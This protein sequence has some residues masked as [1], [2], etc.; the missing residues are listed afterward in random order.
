M[1]DSSQEFIVVL[2]TVP[3]SETGARLGRGL[4]EQHLAAC[5]NIIP[6]VRSLY[7]WEGEVKDDAEAQLLIKTRR[8]RYDELAEHIRTHHP[9]S[10]PEI[11]ALPIANG[12]ASYLAWI[13]AQT[14]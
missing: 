7:S 13:A 12:S 5:V 1:A 8:A 11:I 9:Y 4:V 10:E 14:R 3:D 6:G 2:C